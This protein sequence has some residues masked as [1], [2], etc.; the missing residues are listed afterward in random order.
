MTK[1]LM[2]ENNKTGYRLED[3]LEIIRAD[4][5]K[6]CLI[7]AEETSAEARHVMNNNM[8]ILPMLTDAIVLAEESTE[9]LSRKFGHD[10]AATGQPPHQA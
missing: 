2:S 6:R 5:L 10:H 4:I 3:V 7:L 9:V 8:H 1:L